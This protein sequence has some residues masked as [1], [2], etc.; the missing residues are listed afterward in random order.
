[1]DLDKVLAKQDLS[2]INFSQMSLGGR[3]LS[4]KDCR[5]ADFSGAHLGYAD[6]RGADLREADLSNANL[7]AANLT[8][9]DLRGANLTNTNLEKAQLEGADFRN[10]IGLHL[11]SKA[12]VSYLLKS[13][14]LEETQEFIN[15]KEDGFFPISHWG[16]YYLTEDD[17]CT[18]SA[19]PKTWRRIKGRLGELIFGDRQTFNEVRLVKQY[20]QYSQWAYMISRYGFERM[21]KQLNLAPHPVDQ[22]QIASTETLERG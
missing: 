12:L 18:L 21:I 19:D 13:I 15:A 10:A 17:H 2:D 22:N 9:A 16:R 6:L 7:G 4:G 20:K 1:M 3:N 8:G 11:N 14:Q 5:R